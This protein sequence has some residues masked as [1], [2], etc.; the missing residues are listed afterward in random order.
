MSFTWIEFHNFF[1]ALYYSCFCVASFDPHFIAL[2]CCHL[3]RY[4]LT[5]PSFPFVLN[6]HIPFIYLILFLGNR[7]DMIGAK[8]GRL[9]YL[10]CFFG[11]QTVDLRGPTLSTV[12]LTCLQ[13]RKRSREPRARSTCSTW[14]ATKGHQLEGIFYFTDLFAQIICVSTLI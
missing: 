10:W 3:W 4:F 13:G 6:F 14:T 12:P 5:S 2:F 7:S 1:D 11:F 8:S 9:T